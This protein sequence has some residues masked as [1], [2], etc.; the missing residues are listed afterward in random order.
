MIKKGRSKQIY[1]RFKTD[2]S[3]LAKI[4]LA[5]ASLSENGIFP[6]FDLRAGNVLFSILEIVLTFMEGEF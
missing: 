5:F 1:F 4:S 6:S 2:K 3:V